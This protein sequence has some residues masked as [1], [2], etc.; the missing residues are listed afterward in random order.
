MEGPTAFV[1]NRAHWGGAIMNVE[2]S[3]G[4]DADDDVQEVKV[5]T[6]SYPDDTAFINN[7]AD[8]SDCCMF[9]E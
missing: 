3:N 9:R 8:V 2:T 5:P 6:I 7:S 4:R 1:A